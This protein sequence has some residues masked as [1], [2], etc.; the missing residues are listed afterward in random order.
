MNRKD[1]HYPRA[2]RRALGTI[3]GSWVAYRVD[4][5]ESPAF[6]ELNLS[7]RRVLNRLEIEHM[8]H[9][10]RENG[11]L[12]TTYDDFQVY[13]IHRH[14]IG[15]AIRCLVALGFLEVTEAGRA[16]NAEWRRPN[17]FRLTYLKCLTENLNETDEWRRIETDEGARALAKAARSATV[18]KKEKISSGGKRQFL[19]TESATETAETI[20]QKT[21]LMA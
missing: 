21:A 5:L 12:A 16:G 2:G 6:C 8:S 17:R 15:P 13:G 4:M 7:E 3:R 11:I 14:S 9:G 19:V 20:V 1:K 10:G 18:P